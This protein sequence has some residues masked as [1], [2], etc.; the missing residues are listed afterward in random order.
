[1]QNITLPKVQDIAIRVGLVLV[2]VPVV[3]GVLVT[4]VFAS[5]G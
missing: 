2:M 4:A 3:S 1:M 5:I